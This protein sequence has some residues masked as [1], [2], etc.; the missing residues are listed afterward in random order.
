[1]L[2]IHLHPWQACYYN[3]NK[4]IYTCNFVCVCVYIYIHSLLCCIST[5]SHGSQDT[6]IKINIW[7]CYFV[8]IR[9]N[10][11]ICYFVCVGV[12]IHIFT[13]FVTCRPAA[14][15]GT[16]VRS[17]RVMGPYTPERADKSNSSPPIFKLVFVPTRSRLDSQQIR[18]QPNS[19]FVRYSRT[20]VESSACVG[21]VD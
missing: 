9:I 11:W 2:Y 15:A 6:S 14:M 19:G 8:S 16:L 21:A 12:C 18:L 3:K 13:H 7:K 20:V 1:M 5:C 4:Y 10:I 17:E